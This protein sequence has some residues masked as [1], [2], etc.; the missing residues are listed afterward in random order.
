MQ[1]G[2]Q[3]KAGGIP[4]LIVVLVVVISASVLRARSEI[5][6]ATISTVYGAA[7]GYAS[8]LTLNRKNGPQ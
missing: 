1:P 4:H 5:D 2:N 6:T 8:A 3:D 7:L